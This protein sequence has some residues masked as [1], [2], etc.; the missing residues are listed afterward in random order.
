M[1]YLM[2]A[3]SAVGYGIMLLLAIMAAGA[4]GRDSAAAS[5]KDR[6]PPRPAAQSRRPVKKKLP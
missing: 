2:T 3:A 1:E 5:H 4:L 6:P